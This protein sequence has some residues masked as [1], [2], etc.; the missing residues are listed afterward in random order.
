MMKISKVLCEVVN[1]DGKEETR[2]VPIDVVVAEILLSEIPV[3][4]PLCQECQEVKCECEGKS[5]QDESVTNNFNKG[6]YELE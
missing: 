3:D 1:E 5:M 2:M 6:Q 4:M